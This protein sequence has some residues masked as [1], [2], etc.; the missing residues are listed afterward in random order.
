MTF[1]TGTDYS[2]TDSHDIRKLTWAL[3]SY[4]THLLGGCRTVPNR[5]RE[6]ALQVAFARGRARKRAPP[7]SSSS[8]RRDRARTGQD[9]EHRQQTNCEPSGNLPLKLGN[10]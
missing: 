2:N 5:G 8:G 10:Q 1:F 4:P 9:K 3:A 7:P 6:A